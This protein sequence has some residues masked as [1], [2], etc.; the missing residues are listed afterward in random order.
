MPRDDGTTRPNRPT[1]EIIS[2]RKGR[3]RPTRDEGPA[4]TVEAIV[5][6]AYSIARTEG[7]DAIQIRRIARTLGVWPQAIYHY[8]PSKHALFPLVADRA[9]ST[10]APATF[11]A[12]APWEE[13]MLDHFRRTTDVYRRHPGL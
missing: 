6:A 12:G 3:R 8:V 2:P 7:L 1:T 4:V 9:L 10:R 11:A 5:D 13:R